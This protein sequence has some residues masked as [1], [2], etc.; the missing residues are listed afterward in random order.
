MLARDL[1]KTN[2]EVFEFS[3]NLQ[4]RK[5]ASERSRIAIPAF[6]ALVKVQFVKLP[7]EFAKISTAHSHL[8]SIGTKVQSSAIIS[9]LAVTWILHLK[10]ICLKVILHW[11]IVSQ[12][13]VKE[14]DIPLILFKS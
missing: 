8:S 10:D 9:D 1:S 11:L 6:V 13:T 4:P 14:G 3:V 5:V 12:L 2:I 7:L